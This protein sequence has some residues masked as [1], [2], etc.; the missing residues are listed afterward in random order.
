M[1]VW[2]K[3]AT[4]YQYFCPLMMLR[5]Q[6][7]LQWIEGLGQH[8]TCTFAPRNKNVQCIFV[9][10]DNVKTGKTIIFLVKQCHT[11]LIYLNIFQTVTLL[12]NLWT[13]IYPFCVKI[14]RV[15][16]C[17][18]LY[19]FDATIAHWLTQQFCE[20]KWH[21][22]VHYAAINQSILSG[23]FPSLLL[24]TLREWHKTNLAKSKSKSI[25]SH[26]IHD[27]LQ[28]YLCNLNF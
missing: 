19:I 11:S 13:I 1:V 22:F 23:Y 27:K 12:S 7:M 18:I 25:I 4:A 5:Q 28:P 17:S 8:Q 16:F 14:Y 24:K 3:H 21:G 20:Y 10:C 6:R 26:K 15:C 9:L 2:Q